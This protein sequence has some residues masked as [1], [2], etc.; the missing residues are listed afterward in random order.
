MTEILSFMPKP[1]QKEWNK[2]L[3]EVKNTS[4]VKGLIASDLSLASFSYYVQQDA[5]YLQQDALL[6]QQLSHRCRKD[7]H[8]EMADFFEAMRQDAIAAE[9][10][11]EDVF[12]KHYQLKRATQIS[13]TLQEY[14]GFIEE[15]INSSS[16]EVGMCALFPCFGLYL[17]M[18]QF[19][20]EK[21][22]QPNHYQL[23]IETYKDD[24]YVAYTKQFNHFIAQSYLKTS[25]SEQNKM[26]HVLLRAAYYELKFLKEID[27]K[28]ES[29]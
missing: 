19:I 20:V 16:L 5:W 1:W 21:A 27:F 29:L 24:S 8:N 18:T 9:Q 12:F 13:R 11:M 25:S 4:F 22:I 2:L 17:D 7:F 23:W 28:I 10:A 15:C 3:E 6:F 26:K 14:T